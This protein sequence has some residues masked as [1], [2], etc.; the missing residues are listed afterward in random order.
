MYAI[1][2]N[3]KSVEQSHIQ[4]IYPKRYIYFISEVETSKGHLFDQLNGNLKFNGMSLRIL[5]H[6]CDGNIL[7]QFLR[8]VGCDRFGCRRL[9]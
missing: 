8:A 1:M 4:A 3:L 2:R 7:E 5:Q 9:V 6:V